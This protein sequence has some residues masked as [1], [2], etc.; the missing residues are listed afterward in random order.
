MLRI[1]L[2]GGIGSGKS[3]VARLFA[4]HGAPVI[5]ADIIAHRLTRPGERATREILT[6]F[7]PEI[8]FDDGID[9]QRLAQR[10]FRNPADRRRLEAILHPLVRT[11]M[12]EETRR[13]DAPYCLLVIPLLI[14]ADQRELVDRVLVVD[15]D[16]QAQISRVQQRD[17]KSEAD[18][19][20]I[21][22]AQVG[23]EQRLQAA[24]DV[25]VNNGDLAALQTRVES[26]HRKY[27]A[28]ATERR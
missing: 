7:G 13:L 1:G 9:R 22:D 6:A 14:E 24:D 4:A 18:I 27:L 3:T 12:E 11:A 17:G 23:R 21:L 2:T 5:D 25:I 8:A 19:R 16:E 26:L 20:A 15:T 28:L 10:V